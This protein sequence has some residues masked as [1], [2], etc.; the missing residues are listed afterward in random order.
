MMASHLS[1][2]RFTEI[3]MAGTSSAAEEAHLASCVACRHR[4][5]AVSALLAEIGH[6][7]A[8]EAD[9]AFPPERLLR[10]RTRILRLVDRGAHPARV[11]AFPAGSRWNTPFSPPRPLARWVALAAAAGLVVGLVTDRVVSQFRGRP[12]SLSAQ[13]TFVGESQSFAARPASGA[14]SDDEFLLEVEAA[15]LSAG[16]AALRPL[17]QLTPRAWDVAR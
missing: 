13:R 8:L 10:L 1:E 17:D 15:V 16:P 5:R 6:A 3:A 9:S 14:A 12:P 7:A 4:R 2:D 11:I